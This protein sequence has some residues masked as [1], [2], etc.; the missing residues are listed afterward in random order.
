MGRFDRMDRIRRAGGSIDLMGWIVAALTNVVVFV[1]VCDRCRRCQS[2]WNY[3]RWILD[4]LENA[5][6]PLRDAKRGTREG[7]RG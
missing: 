4:C 1:I 6:R 3:A 7:G 2:R 5:S